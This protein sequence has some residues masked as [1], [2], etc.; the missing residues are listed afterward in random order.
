MTAAAQASPAPGLSEP[1]WTIRRAGPRDLDRLAELERLCFSPP[2]PPPELAREIAEPRAVLLVTRRLNEAV[3]GY[4]LFRHAA[5]EA[6]LLRLGVAPGRRRQGLGEALLEAGLSQLSRLGVT[7]C[8]LEVR[9]D[10][11]PA[12]SLYGRHGFLTVGRR[13]GYYGDGTDALLLTRALS[14]PSIPPAFS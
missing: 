1:G 6:E 5:G 12:L 14:A 2:W 8:H 11:Q 10:N 7:A 3:S 9:V 13:P 4:A